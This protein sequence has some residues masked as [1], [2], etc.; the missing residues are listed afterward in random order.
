MYLDDLRA[1]AVASALKEYKTADVAANLMAE[2]R[3]KMDKLL[4]SLEDDE[5]PA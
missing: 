2:D 3:K 1:L 4:A 5:E